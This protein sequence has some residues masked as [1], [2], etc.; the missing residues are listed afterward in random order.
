M[1][2]I[3]VVQDD[4]GCRRFSGDDIG[5]VEVTVHKSDLRIL[6]G[7]FGA[8]VGVADERCDFK[9]WVGVRDVVEGVA[10]DVASGAGAI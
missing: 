6:R 8:F 5:A 10:T 9:V 2:A 7:D 4:V 3:R 1:V